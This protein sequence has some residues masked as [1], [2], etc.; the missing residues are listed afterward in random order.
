MVRK[1]ISPVVQYKDGRWGFNDRFSTGKRLQVRRLTK[2]E[3]QQAHLELSIHIANGRKDLATIDAAEL[4]D[5]RAEIKRRKKC[6]TIKEL[7]EKFIAVKIADTQLN[8]LYVQNLSRFTLSFEEEFGA[9]KASDITADE[10]RAFLDGLRKSPRHRNNIRDA[11][12]ALYRFGRETKRLPDTKTEVE[13]VKRLKIRRASEIRL[14]QPELF[15]RFIALARSEYVPQYALNSFAGIRPEEIR[16]KHNSPKDPLRWED[17]F[18]R[19][20]FVN[21]RR[22]TAKTGNGRHVPINTALR[23]FLE[24]YRGHTGI[25][26]EHYAHSETNRICRLLNIDPREIENA[27]RHSFGTY[28]HAANQNILVLTEIMGTGISVARSQYVR[29]V[30]IKIAKAWFAIRPKSHKSHKIIRLSAAKIA[31]G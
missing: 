9:R 25:I 1:L 18:W 13:T 11:I 8:P 16:P 4:A 3:A 2:A 29:P 28:Y 17:V 21:V 20:G 31:S 15:A 19:Q 10:F 14:W 22:E 5:I 12:V 24:P 30:P 7:R 27:G 23:S 6:P 26:A